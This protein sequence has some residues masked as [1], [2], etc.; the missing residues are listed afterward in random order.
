VIAE[1]REENPLTGKRHTSTDNHDLDRQQGDHLCDSP[2]ECL[3]RTIHHALRE[4]IASLGRLGNHFARELP[5]VTV[6][7]LEQLCSIALSGGP[8]GK[9]LADTDLD[10]AAAGE[11][12]DRLAGLGR[13]EAR[14]LMSDF[15]DRRSVRAE[16]GAVKDQAAADTGSHRDVKH[17]ALS[18]AG[19]EP[20]LGQCGHVAVVPQKCRHTKGLS[21]PI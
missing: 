9:G 15:R 6:T 16:E 13:V 1:R 21:A 3:A 18:S 20:G 14:S 2:A 17:A 5:R 8:L 11:R 19:P 4:R 7:E 12:L 10:P